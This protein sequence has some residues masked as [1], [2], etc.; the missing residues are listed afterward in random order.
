MGCANSGAAALSKTFI[1]LHALE[2]VHATAFSE[3]RSAPDDP[4]SAGSGSDSSKQPPRLHGRQ[5]PVQS[6]WPGR[7]AATD[8]SGTARPRGVG[9]DTLRASPGLMRSRHS[10]LDP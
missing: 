3:T 10:A 2:S 7:H 9:S 5:S 6:Y 4:R 8:V 1:L